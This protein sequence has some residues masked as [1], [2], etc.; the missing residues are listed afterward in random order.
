M[1]KNQKSFHQQ[2][3]KKKFIEKSTEKSEISIQI[4]K[5]NRQKIE[6]M[7]QKIHNF[8]LTKIEKKKN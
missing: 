7:D 3:K 5:V 6:I 8:Q 2:I 1:K 4:A